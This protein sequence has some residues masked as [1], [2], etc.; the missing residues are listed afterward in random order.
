[1]SEIPGLETDVHFGEIDKPLPD[2][3]D[4]ES[5]VDEVDPD[6]EE[7]ETP[8]DVVSILGF[9]PLELSEDADNDEEP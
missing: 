9:D 3:R 4:D 5:V 8:E 1:M 6:D 7:I 2:W